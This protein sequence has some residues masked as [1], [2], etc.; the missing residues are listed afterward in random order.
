M[1]DVLEWV[2][3]NKELT[4]IVVVALLLSLFVHPIVGGLAAAA[5]VLYRT[6][7]LD[8]WVVRLRSWLKSKL[9]DL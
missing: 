7:N 5:Y 9:G 1:K 3:A 8:A 6:G 2:K 4:T